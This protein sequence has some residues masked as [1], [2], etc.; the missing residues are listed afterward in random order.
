ME[1][2]LKTSHFNDEAAYLLALY[3][4][5]AG[6][7]AAALAFIDG[8]RGDLRRDLSADLPPRMQ[9]LR[10]SIAAGAVI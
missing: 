10:T 6:Q 3:R 4:A 1:Q 9:R 7:P 5:R 2:V 8:Y